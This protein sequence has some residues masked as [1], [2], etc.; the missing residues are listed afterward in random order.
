MLFRS[1]QSVA[2]ATIPEFKTVPKLKALRDLGKIGIYGKNYGK[3]PRGF[4]FS[5]FLDDG[6]PLGITRADLLCDGLDRFYPGVPR[7]QRFIREHIVKHASISTLWGRWQ[8]L[9]NARSR[10]NGLVNRAWRQALNYP[11]QGSGQEIMCYAII[12]ILA[13]ELLSRLGYV[14]SLCV[15]DELVGWAPEEHTDECLLRIQELM[16]NCVELLAPLKVEGHTGLSWKEA[17]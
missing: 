4:A 5:T 6:S 16:V 10:Q 17:K 3:S 1:D 9:P 11:M 14:L 2:S 7:Y 15:H 12:D 8:P 13:D